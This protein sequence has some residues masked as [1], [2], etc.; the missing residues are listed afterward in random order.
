MT[1]LNETVRELLDDVNP[2]VLGTINPDGS[3]QTSVVWV[4]RDGDDLLIPSAAGRRKESNLL[5]DPRASLT[6]FDR[7]DPLQYAEV[8]GTAEITED[9][10]RRLAIE[11]AEHYEGP[12]A[13]Q[14]YLE[15]P[16]EI[17]RIVI[18]I[19]PHRVVGTAAG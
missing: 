17:V 9:V 1:M 18:R 4:G 6:V 14:E 10:G 16:P 13:G 3:P 7:N 12:G 5:R 2:A 8:R 15:L 11:L 19:T